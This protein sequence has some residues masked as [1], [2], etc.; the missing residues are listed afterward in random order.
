MSPFSSALPGEN[1][2]EARISAEQ[3]A[4]LESGDTQRLSRFLSLYS[5][6]PQ[7]G[8]VRWR[9][10]Q[11]LIEQREFQRAEFLLLEDRGSSDPA[12]AANATAA[13]AALWNQLG[14][15][16]EAASLLVELEQRFASVPDSVSRQAFEWARLH[17]IDPLRSRRAGGDFCSADRAA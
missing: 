5:R 2:A 16:Q 14:L 9:L 12:T 17:R 4:A 10:A 3:K 6:W 8:Q 1:R 11:K 7:A 15:Y 13:L